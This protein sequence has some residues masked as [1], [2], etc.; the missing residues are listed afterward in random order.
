MTLNKIA[1]IFLFVEC[2]MIYHLVWEISQG[3]IALQSPFAD[4]KHL[5]NI[6]I[7]K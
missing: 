1:H 5:A 3:T 2:F 6:I 4:I 7:I